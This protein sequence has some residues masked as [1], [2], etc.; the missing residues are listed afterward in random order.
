M[1]NENFK[2]HE[3]QGKSR[4]IYEGPYVAKN[5]YFFVL[6]LSNY[7]VPEGFPKGI[8]PRCRK[9]KCQKLTLLNKVV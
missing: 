5:R 2:G 8:F 9:K 3:N 6:L 4:K 7:P 1:L